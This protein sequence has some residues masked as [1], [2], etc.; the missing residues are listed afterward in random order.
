L[1]GVRQALRHQ[2]SARAHA[3]RRHLVLCRCLPAARQTTRQGRPRLP[4]PEIGPF[5]Q[6]DGGIPVCLG[7][8]VANPI[9]VAGQGEARGSVF[10]SL[11]VFP[12]D[13]GEPSEGFADGLG[14]LSAH[15]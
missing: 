13:D 1:W 8:V 5:Q 15:R 4:G 14:P 7:T 11:P 3:S 9:T 2:L 12:Q 6:W 10:S